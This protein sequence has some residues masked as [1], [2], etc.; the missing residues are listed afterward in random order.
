MV[1]FELNSSTIHP[2]STA[3]PWGTFGEGSKALFLSSGLCAFEALAALGSSLIRSL[4]PPPLPSHVVMRWDCE[5]TRGSQN[6]GPRRPCH[7]TSCFRFLIPAPSS[8]RAAAPPSVPTC[9]SI[10]PFT[11]IPFCATPFPRCGPRYHYIVIYRSEVTFLASVYFPLL[12][13]VLFVFGNR[14]LKTTHSHP[15]VHALANL[16]TSGTILESRF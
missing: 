4:F 14:L 1:L 12:I 3:D 16:R 6:R 11:V 7:S 10:H 9:I 8:H 5:T 2:R 15:H 13:C